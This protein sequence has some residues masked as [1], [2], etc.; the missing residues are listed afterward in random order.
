MPKLFQLSSCG[1]LFFKG[2]RRLMLLIGA[3]WLVIQLN[4]LGVLLITFLALLYFE[5]AVRRRRNYIKSFNSALRTTIQING[6]L[7]QTARAFSSSGPLRRASKAYETRLASGGSP[8]H[9]AVACRLP[10]EMETAMAFS[11]PAEKTQSK[12]T[13]TSQQTVTPQSSNN[14]PTSS[15][16]YYLFFVCIAAIAFTI[17]YDTFILPTLATIS[18]E[19][20]SSGNG[21]A[22]IRDGSWLMLTAFFISIGAVV[23]YLTVVVGFFPKVTSASWMP[24]LPVAATRNSEMLLGIATA[25][26]SNYPLKN[27]FELGETIYRGSE[28]KRFR[29]ALN[30]IERGNTDTNAIRQAGWISTSDEAWLQDA[31][32]RRMA[33]I[34]RTISRQNIRHAEG[35]L[36]WLMAILFP[37]VLLCLA[38]TMEPVASSFFSHLYGLT[39]LIH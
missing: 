35:N 19:Y 10:L 15:Q 17:F 14:L 16:L 9:N 8:L 13:G 38:G 27:F 1:E 28:R 37:L 2:I 31:T 3:G 22:Q 11:L 23:F 6:S 21:I 34:L 4:V 20:Q 26:D 33:E 39:R 12:R 29:V 25:L 36:N 32:P 7:E 24:L 30:A 5:H 18:S